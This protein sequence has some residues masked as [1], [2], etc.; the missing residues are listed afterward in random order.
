[1]AT[2]NKPSAAPP[3]LQDKVNLLVELP[4]PAELEP[5][6]LGN[7]D[8]VGERVR[9][10]AAA[11]GISESLINALRN[12]QR[13]NPTMSTMRKLADL[14]KIDP[15]YFTDGPLGTQIFKELRLLQTL[16]ETK[17]GHTSQLK[18][19]FRNHFEL[20]DKGAATALH[21]LEHLRDLEAQHLATKREATGE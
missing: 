1:M 21:M 20:S 3:T 8:R 12:G 10:I 15:A 7:L 14:Y 9:A 18:I 16:A 13:S 11:A 4:L 6:A 19:A 2:A 17:R 5:S